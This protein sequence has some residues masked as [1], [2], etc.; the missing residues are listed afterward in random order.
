MGLCSASPEIFEAVANAGFVASMRGMVVDT[1]D[2]QVVL[3]YVSIGR[4][5]WGD[6]VF[7]V[8]ELLCTR[9]QGQ[10]LDGRPLGHSFG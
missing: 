3:R 4:V 5:V 2:A 9:P 10:R 1:I 8:A 6:V 7:A